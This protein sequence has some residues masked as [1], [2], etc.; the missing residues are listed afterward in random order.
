MLA[1]CR[2]ASVFVA[3]T[4]LATAGAAS[5]QYRL[6]VLHA[7]P[8]AG[9]VNPSSIVRGSDGNL[10]GTSGIPF[11]LPGGSST[12]FRINQAGDVTIL[13][14]FADGPEGQNLVDGLVQG[15]DGLLY[16][17]T[18]DGGQ[19]LRGTLFKLDPADGRVTVVYEFSSSGGA[20]SPS[21]SGPLAKLP[22]GDLFGVLRNGT[23]GN[24]LAFRIPAG[25]E[26]A[27]VHTFDPLTE[28]RPSSALVPGPDGNLYGVT[29]GPSTFFRMTPDGGV[30]AL[31][32]FTADDGT[33]PG[34]FVLANDGNFY[35]R[36][37][38]GT[39]GNGTILRITP[40]GATTVVHD[41]AGGIGGANP[42]GSLIQAIDGNLY[43]TT[44]DGGAADAGI[45]Y[46]I[47]LAGAFAALHPFDGGTEGDSP[48]GLAQAN[49]GLLYGVAP[50]GGPSNKGTVF[51]MTTSGMVTVMRAGSVSVDGGNNPRAP[52]VRASDGDLYGTTIAGGASALGTVFRI[53]RE[54]VI[55]NLASFDGGALGRSPRTALVQASNGKLYGTT[56]GVASDP[57]YGYPGAVAA[58]LF[59][60][61]PSGAVTLFYTFP[62]SVLL[63]PI[64]PLVQ[65]RDGN[66]YG[67]TRGTYMSTRTNFG[68]VFKITLDGQFTTLTA[69]GS[70]AGVW[71][72]GALLETPD[73]SFYGTATGRVF[74]D[75][76]SVFRVTPAGSLSLVHA[77]DAAVDGARPAA[78][79]VR[80]FDG[81]YYGTTSDFA[82]HGS[83]FRMAPDG[84]TT[85]LHQ[86]TGAPDGSKPSGT[87]IQGADGAFYGTTSGGGANRSGAI[88]RVT[89]TG[90][91][92]VIYSFAGGADGA[93][94][95][96]G[97]VQLPDGRFY[98]TTS[99]GG[100]SG[101]GVV[102]RLRSV[103]SNGLM[104]VD[105]PADGSTITG[106]FDV[107]GWA[108]DAGAASGT[109]VSAIHVYATRAGGTQQFLG[110]A[111]YG[112]A[113][114]DVGSIFGSEFTNSGYSLTVPYL[115]P[116]SYTIAAYAYSTVTNSFSL[117]RSV[118][119]VVNTPASNPLLVVD[120]PSN[121]STVG[122][123]FTVGGW[124]I[125]LG[126]P[127]G[128]GTDAV[129]VYLFPASGSPIF[130]GVAARTNRPDVAAAFGPQFLA[131]GYVLNVSGMSLPVGNAQVAVYARSTL[132]QSFN[133]VATV[134]V[135]VN[136]TNSNPAMFIDEP[137]NGST[138]GASLTVSGW[139]IDL[140]AATG[141]GVNQI[142]VW[143]LPTSGAPGAFLGEAAYGIAR[144][145]VGSVFGTQFTSSG[146]TLT[147][148][149]AALPPNQYY[150]VVFSR[151]T[152]TGTFSFAR[153][154]TATKP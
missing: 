98:G 56:P 57:L 4:M 95:N 51:R 47:S 77:F 86:F 73:G 2:F 122:Q 83:L 66:L 149:T 74:F 23:T 62:V 119:V 116:G 44:T 71:P 30:T 75:A 91:Y 126:A 60:V 36:A 28:G 10:Y 37:S 153:F 27:F 9:M 72:E 102:F 31:H 121:N 129:H 50:L 131:S 76:G 12:V 127:T 138:I 55:S 140:G 21:P 148:N 46:R 41:F 58:T 115:A 8:P 112:N 79:L 144:P 19:L 101:T 93:Y 65:G 104:A 111:A 7:F 67:T 87:L 48:T 130:L 147:V 26:L 139:S 54:G 49:D 6:D 96:G 82:T 113:R 34:G 89:S 114:S 85:L 52:L 88:F 1:R 145:D 39:T 70:G 142:H 92:S 78:G 20:S 118:N 90:E 136:P 16:G 117:A 99:A 80:G 132:T 38:G 18:R 40:N 35:G 69:M 53:S 5:A 15:A 108:I 106:S 59:Q 43:G 154:V 22:N 133:A 84:T 11:P 24:G 100:V 13:H 45:A 143:A 25:G 150:I 137:A 109:G 134:N 151:S 42:S 97:L 3:L 32:T 120:G 141:T 124:S 63:G 107:S 94:P 135:I 29:D 110:V 33:D 68:S 81:N 103:A 125:D 123:S 105:G 152:V 128:V 64:A 14:S 61:D 17:M 146:Y